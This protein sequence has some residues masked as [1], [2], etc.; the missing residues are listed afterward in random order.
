VVSNMT[1]P[2]SRCPFCV[3]QRVSVTNSLAM[4]FPVI[5]SQWHPTATQHGERVWSRRGKP[6]PAAQL[7][8]MPRRPSAERVRSA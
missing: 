2:N 4:R 6:V 3:N 5:A 7:T 8:I 1:R